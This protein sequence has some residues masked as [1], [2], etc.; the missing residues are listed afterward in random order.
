MMIVTHHWR[1]LIS[2]FLVLACIVS[3]QMVAFADVPDDD[4][5]YSD[6]SVVLYSKTG[7]IAASSF[8]WSVSTVTSSGYIIRTYAPKTISRTGN[9]RLIGSGVDSACYWTGSWFYATLPTIPAESGVPTAEEIAAAVSGLVIV[10]DSP[11]TT[12]SVTEP[13]TSDI[14]VSA[15]TKPFNDYSLSEFFLLCMVVLLFS[16][17]VLFLSFSARRSHWK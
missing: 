16:V 4:L 6:D 12:D 3:I 11:V 2:V 9:Y 10:L 8:V 13:I 15:L 14:A 5:M 7:E 1:R 17:I